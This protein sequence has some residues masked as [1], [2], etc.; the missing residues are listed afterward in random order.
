[1][2]AAT[3]CADAQQAAEGAELVVLAVEPDGILPILSDLAS[4]LTA[5]NPLVVSVAAGVTLSQMQ[6]LAPTARLVR[7]MPNTA[8]AIGE[9]ASAFVCAPSCL[10]SDA[11]LCQQLFAPTGLCLELPREADIQAVASLA[12]SAPAFFYELLDAM[13]KQGVAQGLSLELSLQLA[14]QAMRGTASLQQQTGKSPNALRNAITSPN[15]ATLA[16]LRRL[17]SLHVKENWQSV[18]Q[19]CSDR[20]LEMDAERS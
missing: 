18:M 15:G 20:L 6:A 5:T 12:G 11:A 7:L 17:N 14:A 3:V 19:A 16:G 10:P 1:M 4:L 13:A 9:G 8:V 2:P